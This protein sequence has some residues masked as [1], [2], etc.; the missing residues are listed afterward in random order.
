MNKNPNNY[1]PL[2]ADKFID[3]IEGKDDNYT[4]PQRANPKMGLAS[5]NKALEAAGQEPFCTIYIPNSDLRQQGWREQKAYS[6]QYTTANRPDPNEPFVYKILAPVAW[7]RGINSSTGEGTKPVLTCGID[8]QECEFEGQFFIYKVVSTKEIQLFLCDFLSQQINGVATETGFTITSSSFKTVSLLGNK[9]YNKGEEVPIKKIKFTDLETDSVVLNG[10]KVDE[11]YIGGRE[12]SI[13]S[14]SIA[15]C[16]I[17]TLYIGDTEF[18]SVS[19]INTTINN[20]F[21]VNGNVKFFSLMGSTPLEKEVYHIEKFN[22]ILSEQSNKGE[23]F[24]RG[25]TIAKLEMGGVNNGKIIIADNEIR[26][27]VFDDLTN[28]GDLKLHDIRQINILSM[29]DS[30]MGKSEFSNIDLSSTTHVEV[31]DSN[32]SDI[33]LMNTVFPKY[34][35]GSSK[36]DYKGIREA[37][38]QLK[39][40]SGKQG[41]RIQELAY[42]ACEMDAYQKDKKAKKTADEKSILFLNKITNNHGQSWT[43][44]LLCLLVTIPLFMAIKLVFGNTY[45]WGLNSAEVGQYLEFA[46]NPLHNFDILFKEE[47]R[48]NPAAM[49]SA[50]ILDIVSKL[51][52][53]FIL[54]QLVRAF[55]KY[56][57]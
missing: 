1:I 5:M 30:S 4:L 2:D 24:I 39:F 22:L 7:Y 26:K 6:G 25:A 8:L 33:V 48:I 40:V 20:S 18:E 9:G 27:I 53:G 50:K 23:Y 14:L 16:D 3:I 43:R 34:L 15:N 49:G 44:A 54:F 17:S 36:G 38:R 52:E 10:M 56:V 35:V 41:N 21:T 37:F 55:R 11:L 12:G 45:A 51:I 31:V 32:L 47:L 13:K 29:K 46:V 57:K 19:I 28:T 42:E